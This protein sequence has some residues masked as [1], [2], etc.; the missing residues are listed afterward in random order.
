M[1]TG[2]DGEYLVPVLLLP[3]RHRSG[4]S[5]SAKTLRTGVYMLGQAREQ[6][7]AVTRLSNHIQKYEY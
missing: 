1:G 6:G 4:T 7:A 5:L 3:P 2:D